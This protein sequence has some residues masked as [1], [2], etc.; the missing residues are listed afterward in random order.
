MRTGI[1]FYLWIFFICNSIQCNKNENKCQ[2]CTNFFNAARRVLFYQFRIYF[3]K[4]RSLKIFPTHCHVVMLL[5]LYTFFCF[6]YFSLHLISICV[7]DATKLHLV[8]HL[9]LYNNATSNNVAIGN[10]LGT[11]KQ[12]KQARAAACGWER[13]REFIL[14]IIRSIYFFTNS[15]MWWHL[16]SVIIDFILQ[17]RSI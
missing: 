14:C 7:F 10:S 2:S 8:L 16:D 15:L 11:S 3:L 17:I 6:I 9:L 13:E 4:V 1:L 5:I 12:W